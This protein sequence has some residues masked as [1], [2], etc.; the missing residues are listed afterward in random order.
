MSCLPRGCLWRRCD[1]PQAAESDG[2]ITGGFVKAL[3]TELRRPPRSGRLGTWRLFSALWGSLSA[4]PY[5]TVALGFHKVTLHRA[6][7]VPGCRLVKRLTH[8][9]LCKQPDICKAGW[10][11]LKQS[12]V[13]TSLNQVHLFHLCLIDKL[14]VIK[15]NF[16]FIQFIQIF[17][18]VQMCTAL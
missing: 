15:T 11:C 4:D 12:A 5:G 1:V 6:C 17:F 2:V 16:R 10:I 13:E 18:L 14:G 3:H 7:S 9:W 8:C